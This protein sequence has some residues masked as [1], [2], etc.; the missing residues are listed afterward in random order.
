[1]LNKELQNKRRNHK[2]KIIEY[3]SRYRDD[4]IFMIL[5]VKDNL[6]KVPSINADFLNIEQRFESYN[7]Y[8]KHG[9]NFYDK[10]HLIK[11]IF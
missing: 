5:R 6:R 7:F 3:N 9:Y 1:M 11:Q 2:L 8:P 4:L 10:N